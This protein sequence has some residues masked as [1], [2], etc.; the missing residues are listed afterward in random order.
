[1]MQ[2]E[3]IVKIGLGIVG[4]V[5]TLAAS[6][7][8]SKK[9]A[10][11][12]INKLQEQTSTLERYEKALETQEEYV[13]SLEKE[14]EALNKAIEEVGLQ[15]EQAE[16]RVEAVNKEIKTVRDNNEYL[17][18]FTTKADE[19]NEKLTNMMNQICRNLVMANQTLPVKFT[20]D[21]LAE[22][23]FL[24][25]DD[26]NDISYDLSQD[27]EREADRAFYEY[28]HEDDEPTDEERLAEMTTNSNDPKEKLVS[29][30]DQYE[31]VVGD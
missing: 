28:L 27:I 19:E 4:A 15:K 13:Q 16:A 7:F 10:G 5:G 22:I 1:M 18:E 26:I 29:I 23:T 12:A 2:T 11:E 30:F 25:E 21:V 31:D 6:Y 20:E 9:V 17:E 24:S 14:N 3:N 8:V